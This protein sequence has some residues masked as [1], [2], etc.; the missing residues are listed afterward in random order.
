MFFVL[1]LSNPSPLLKSFHRAVKVDSFLFFSLVVSP[2]WPKTLLVTTLPGCYFLFSGPFLPILQ[3]GGSVTVFV[4]SGT[5]VTNF[6]VCT[7]VPF[8]PP[9]DCRSRLFLSS[10]FSCL[11]VFVNLQTYALFKCRSFSFRRQWC[12]RA[13]RSIRNVQLG[14]FLG[15]SFS[16]P[17]VPAKYSLWGQICLSSSPALFFPPFLRTVEW[18]GPVCSIWTLTFSLFFLLHTFRPVSRLLFMGPLHSGF[19]VLFLFRADFFVPFFLCGLSLNVSRIWRERIFRLCW[20]V[21][22]PALFFFSFCCTISFC[23]APSLVSTFKSTLFWF[24]THFLFFP[25]QVLLSNLVRTLF[26]H[27]IPIRL[28]PGSLVPGFT[29]VRQRFFLFTPSTFSPSLPRHPLLRF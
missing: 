25:P 26:G 17:L 9:C 24:A 27:L 21:F 1:L 19:L 20:W 5:N 7:S 13:A 18:G 29:V 11:L 10:L 22:I 28:S 3:P 23:S 16:L 15:P 4:H 2:P 14:S 8:N 12:L 6:L